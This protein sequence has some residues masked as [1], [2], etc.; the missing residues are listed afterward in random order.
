MELKK[1]NVCINFDIWKELVI[2]MVIK[3]LLEGTERWESCKPL[4]FILQE[5]S[6]TRQDIS[7]K[8]KLI[9]DMFKKEVGSSKYG[10]QKNL[11]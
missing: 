3:Q 2:C 1:L 5:L 9:I 10:A 7:Q 6:Y 8:I 11:R 4:T